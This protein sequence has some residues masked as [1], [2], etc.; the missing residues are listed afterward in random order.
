MKLQQ[1]LVLAAKKMQPGF[2]RLG[3]ILVCCPCL[4]HYKRCRLD[5]IL[6]FAKDLASPHDIPAINIKARDHTNDG[7]RELDPLVRLDNAL[8]FCCVCSVIA[9]APHAAKG[10]VKTNPKHQP[11]HNV[12]RRTR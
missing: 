6:Q 9:G 7:A 10:L 8:E 3:Y 1:S 4:G 12:L 11:K 2:M 5:S